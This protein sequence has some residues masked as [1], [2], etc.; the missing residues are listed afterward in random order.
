MLPAAAAGSSPPHPLPQC[1]SA[2][3]TRAGG[4]PEP[5][6][7][8]RR[9]LHFSPVDPISEGPQRRR[10]HN[11]FDDL[12]QFLATRK[13][14]LLTSIHGATDY[15][16]FLWFGTQVVCFI[17]LRLGCACSLNRG[18]SK[19]FSS[20][21]SLKFSFLGSLP[22]RYLDLSLPSLMTLSWSFFLKSFFLWVFP[23][24]KESRKNNKSQSTQNLSCSN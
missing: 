5:P 18:R 14:S 22:P 1:L 23:N 12:F 19:V 6:L 16:D 10:S 13:F 15:V 3:G 20:P 24:I 9:C 7:P 2:S 4:G 21:F 8:E 11:L 17:L